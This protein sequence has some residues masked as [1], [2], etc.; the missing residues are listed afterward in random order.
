MS[1]DEKR[2][3]Q[4]EYARKRRILYRLKHPAKTRGV[5]KGHKFLNRAK[6]ARVISTGEPIKK[7]DWDRT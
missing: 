7:Y 3:Y 1:P 4:K 2:L 6:S 5:K